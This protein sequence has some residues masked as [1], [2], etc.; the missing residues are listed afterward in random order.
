MA[1]RWGA[2]WFGDDGVQ[3]VET[4][5]TCGPGVGGW[6]EGLVTSGAVAPTLR[7]SS[8]LLGPRGARPWWQQVPC[9]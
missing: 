5:M 3:R 8:P 4:E 9:R 7:L 6:D 2:G 1:R